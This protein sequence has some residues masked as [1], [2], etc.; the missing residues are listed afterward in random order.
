[1]KLSEYQGFNNWKEI[2]MPTKEELL[3]FVELKR[4]EIDSYGYC[5]YCNSHGTVESGLQ[6][7]ISFD[8]SQGELNI[9]VITL[10]PLCYDAR[11]A[12]PNRHNICTSCG[13]LNS[14]TRKIVIDDNEQEVCAVCIGEID[15]LERCGV[16]GNAHLIDSMHLGHDMY[17]D[18]ENYICNSCIQFTHVCPSCGRFN[19]VRSRSYTTLIDGVLTKVDGCNFCVGNDVDIEYCAS[20]A[21]AFTTD[22][23]KYG[24]CNRCSKAVK[25]TCL[26]C[27]GFNGTKHD[28]CDWCRQGRIHEW[29]YMPEEYIFYGDGIVHYG[30]ELEITGF[31]NSQVRETYPNGRK[32]KCALE[33]ELNSKKENEY[34][35]VNDA[36]I[37]GGFEIVFH[38]RSIDNWF[39][40]GRV[41]LN[42]VI[43]IARKH[44]AVSYKGG[45]CG[46]HI[47]RSIVDLNSNLA[48]A[49][50]MYSIQSIEPYAFIIAQRTGMTN[51][52][53]EDSGCLVRKEYGNFSR[54]K[55][56]F[57][58][59]DV[60]NLTQRDIVGQM[61]T[62][63]HSIAEDHHSAITFGV[64]K[65]TIELRIFRGTLNDET[66]MAYLSF[67][68]L[69]SKWSKTVSLTNLMRK[70]QSTNWKSFSDFV[71][72]QDCKQSQVLKRYAK[73]KGVYL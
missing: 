59:N 29:K 73:S 11:K 27:G 49:T 33:L 45:F 26:N 56:V 53:D 64:D 38:P 2:E 39:N 63:R 72:T 6:L 36:T 18:R 8:E 51:V 42:E 22:L 68:D 44:G 66:I 25:K 19:G 69:L 46:I 4:S 34:Y 24:L 58:D 67:Y 10:C 30:L 48:T 17:S 50:L 12:D 61:N 1:M 5:S 54:M 13:V 16:C 15:G 28:M 47:H 14:R 40:E 20:C 9:N 3:K 43:K 21:Q 70:Q 37:N 31:P 52:I 35:L 32:L 71:K 41:V 7:E 62:W 57:P 55:E 65:E 23:L 60:S